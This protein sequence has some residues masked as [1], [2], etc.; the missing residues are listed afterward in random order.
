MM[1][2]EVEV[3]GK[4]K[5]SM[6]AKYKKKLNELLNDNSMYRKSQ[7]A[8]NRSQNLSMEMELYSEEQ[9]SLLK[10]QN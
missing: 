4:E 5:T 6:E 3:A 9:T 1:K 7:D 2:I 8:L 10:E